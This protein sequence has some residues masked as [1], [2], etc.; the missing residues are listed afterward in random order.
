MGIA[1]PG[2]RQGGGRARVTLEHHDVI[3]FETPSAL[4]DWFDAN[5][6]TAEELW[7]GYHRKATGKPSLTWSQ[8][9]DEALCVG[10]IDSIRKRLDE[11]SFVQR[12]TP[13]RKGQHLECHECRQGRRVDGRGPDATRG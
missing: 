13:R 11:T 3:F 9:V 10:W 6:Q 7:V 1:L 5:H 2:R 4:R 12:F 8:A